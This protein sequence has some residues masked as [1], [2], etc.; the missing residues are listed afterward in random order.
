MRRR[1]YIRTKRVRVP[2]PKPL[3]E[4]IVVMILSIAIFYVVFSLF[5]YGLVNPEKTQM[6]LFM[7]I[8]N[9]ITWN[10]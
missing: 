6:Q 7:Q 2:K 3:R 4:D 1:K 10:W 8:W 5:C 9:A